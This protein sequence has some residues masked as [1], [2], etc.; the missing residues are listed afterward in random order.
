MGRFKALFPRLHPTLHGLAGA[1]R[2]PPISGPMSMRRGNRRAGTWRCST[3]GRSGH[4]P[5]PTESTR[6]F[7]V[8]SS[9]DTSIANPN[10]CGGQ[11]SRIR[12][13]PPRDAV[14]SGMREFESSH[15]S[16]TVT[17]AEKPPRKSAESP[18]LAASCNLTKSL[19]T[20]EFAKSRAK[21]TKSPGAAANIPVFGR[22]T[23]ETR[24]DRPGSWLCH[25]IPAVSLAAVWSVQH[26]GSATLQIEVSLPLVE[27]EGMPK[28]K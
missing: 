24:F 8:D 7:R 18:Q 4:S 28:V 14:R 12:R 20:P 26:F 17:A 1:W 6:W 9:T 22:L 13:A 27:A 11:Y 10:S 5:R 16:Q 19:Q 25:W 21:L 3:T 23:P 2:M 15:S